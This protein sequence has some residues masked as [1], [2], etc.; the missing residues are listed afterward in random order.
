[1]N[2]PLCVASLSQQ[3]KLLHR[4]GQGILVALAILALS[5]NALADGIVTVQLSS[6]GDW[7][8]IGDDFSNEVLVGELGDDVIVE[9]QNGTLI[10]R[11]VPGLTE[12][13]AATISIPKSDLFLP[14]NVNIDLKNGDNMLIMFYLPELITGS[15]SCRMGSGANLLG[16]IPE[17]EVEILNGINIR[18]NRSNRPQSVVLGS[19][20]NIGQ[21]VIYNMRDTSI[22]LKG[23]ENVIWLHD[24]FTNRN[25]SLKTAGA[26]SEIVAISNAVYGRT[27]LRVNPSISSTTQLAFFYFGGKT[28]MNTGNGNNDLELLGATF[29]GEVAVKF[30]RG[31]DRTVINSCV[32]GHPKGAKFD[33]GRGYNLYGELFNTGS[34]LMFKNF[35]VFP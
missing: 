23:S 7:S 30:G 13:T 19:P 28:T 11:I 32:F 25:L 2:K 14:R 34:P 33:G 6:R 1:M 31:D 9:G 4:I 21:N 10:R 18:G 15:L 20:F 12:V 5:Q 3:Q 26:S 16:I 29:A 8:I 35:V 24:S 17:G 27:D 22:D